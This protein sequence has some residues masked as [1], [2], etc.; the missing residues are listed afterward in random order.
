MCFKSFGK[1]MISWTKALTF[2][3][4]NW[5]FGS[6][7]QSWKDLDY[8]ELNQQ[9]KILFTNHCRT[10]ISLVFWIFWLI[11][12]CSPFSLPL[13]I[14]VEWFSIH[15]TKMKLCCLLFSSVFSFLN[16]L[17]HNTWL[18]KEMASGKRKFLQRMKEKNIVFSFILSFPFI[19]HLCFLFLSCGDTHKTFVKSLQGPIHPWARPAP[20]ADQQVE[21]V[22]KEGRGQNQTRKKLE[23]GKIKVS[24]RN[25]VWIMLEKD[26]V[27]LDI[28][29]GKAC[30]CQK[31]KLWQGT[32]K[33]FQ[34]R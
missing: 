6:C 4:E 23:R 15:F 27:D 12:I 26:L 14:N 29:N 8:I 1:N 21:K 7:V 2:R 22:L 24:F 11:T 32:G 25:I 3:K 31:L 34:E 9:N 10:V 20:E 33:C 30:L 16:I 13:L 19:F 18:Q 17:K 28:L 5:H